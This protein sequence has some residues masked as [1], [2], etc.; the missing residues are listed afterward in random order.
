VPP[1]S[2]A[3]APLGLPTARVGADGPVWRRR[4]PQLLVAAAAAVVLGLGAWN[5]V[6]STSRQEAQTSAAQ[7]EQMINDL[8]TPGQ[9]TIA[10]VSH[11]GQAVATV[12]ARD[13]RVQVVS[14]G[15]S[16]N[17]ARSHTYVVWGVRGTSPVALGTFDVV[18]S[19][20]DLRTVGSPQAGIDGFDAFA[21]S[22]E[23]GRKAPSTPR[24]IV[25][26]GQVTS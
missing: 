16:K 2:R 3:E 22:L 1:R 25:A 20:M 24:D 15:L 19:Q 17:D 26:Y 10:P 12:V 21:I 8:L 23:R 9:A 18:S 7:E 11:Q 13:D 4:L 5:V 6:L 14:W